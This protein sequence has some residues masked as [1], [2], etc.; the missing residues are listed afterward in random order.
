[1][2][3]FFTTWLLLGGVFSLF[4]F[5]SVDSFVC[6]QMAH[7]EWQAWSLFLSLFIFSASLM[8]KVWSD[9]FYFDVSCANSLFFLEDPY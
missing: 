1:M 2:L 4:C 3:E 9:Y 5:M 7:Y 6:R 8:M